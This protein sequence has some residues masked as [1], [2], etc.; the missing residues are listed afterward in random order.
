MY[1]VMIQYFTSLYFIRYVIIRYSVILQVYIPYPLV[2]NIFL[3][4]IYFVP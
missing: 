1:K 3:L 2:Y 4:L